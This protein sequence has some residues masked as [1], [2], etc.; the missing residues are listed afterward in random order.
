MS[1]FKQHAHQLLKI[2]LDNKNVDFRDGQWA[3]IENLVEKRKRLLVV[4]RTGWG[5]SIV[6]FLSTRLLRDAGE[7][8]TVVISP[9]LALIRNQV[10]AA[11][12]LGLNAAT[13]NS[14]NNDE[15]PEIETAFLNNQIDVLLISPERLANEKFRQE[16][17][18]P[19]MSQL[20]LG[21]FVVDEAHCISDWG[22]DFRPDYRRIVRILQALPA[23]VPAL[24][25]TATANNRVVQDIKEQLGTGLQIIRGPLVRS[26]LRLQNIVFP[27]KAERMAW[28]AHY[29][30]K[31]PGSGIIYTLTVRD[32]KRLA[33]WLQSQGILADAYYGGKREGVSRAELEQSLLAN[34]LKVLVATTALGMGFDKPDL[35][36]VIHFQR[37]GSVVH[38]YQQVGRAGR[39]ID[40]AYGILLSGEEDKEIIDYFIEN[41]FPPERHTDVILTALDNSDGLSIANLEKKVNLGRNQINKVL[42]LLSIESPSPVEKR[43]SVWYR[44]PISYVPDRKKILELT[45]IR[46]AEQTQMTDYLHS[47]TCLMQ[48]LQQALDDSNAKPCGRCAPCQKRPIVSEQLNQND[49]Q[50]AIEF[51]HRDHI[52]IEPR[53]RWPSGET[54]PVYGWSGTIDETL[55]AEVGYALCLWGD[56]GW[57]DLVKQGKQQFGQFSEQ[58]VK[59]SATMVEDYWQPDPYP[60]WVTCIP[61][62]NHPRLVPD[63]AQRLARKLQL[64][65]QPCIQKIKATAPQKEM[66][67]SFQQSHNLDGA[68]QVKLWSGIQGPVLLVDDMVDSRWTMTIVT[69][70]LRQAGSGPVYP[71]ALAN[72]AKG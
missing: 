11:E 52:P 56:P 40:R 23:N 24:A 21:L 13:I 41:A 45:K 35:G 20:G 55:R 68:F 47:S 6:Y 70:L 28:L 1:Q 15:W 67:N 18:A 37:P 8:P 31:L 48:Y 30:P 53:K 72:T 33:T 4:Q 61:S 34:E 7:G 59:A 58:L 71:L 66:Q 9:L 14:D 29:V 5:K 63:F 46:R 50:A 60:A 3:A 51:L 44:T 26:S 36:F 49:I 12:R 19:A 69:A 16:V 2:A 39:A 10:E 65:F 22:H 42:K 57:G 62:L 64:P 54:F 32:A 17:L 25:T 27:S 38:Y 43:G